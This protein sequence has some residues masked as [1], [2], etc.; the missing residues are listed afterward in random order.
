VSYLE[1]NNNKGA[2]F[3]SDTGEPVLTMKSL[4]REKNSLVMRGALMGAWDSKIYI[5][6]Q[7]LVKMIGIALKP[8]L[9]WYLLCLPILLLRKRKTS[10]EP[11]FKQE[12]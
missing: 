9:I 11:E 2:N 1:D 12:L 5:P 10:S 7:E 4:Y 3:Y 8:G 6:P